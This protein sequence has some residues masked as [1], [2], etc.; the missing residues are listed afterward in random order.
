[1]LNPPPPTWA[2]VTSKK[3]ASPA[4]PT[5]PTAPGSAQRP[6]AR[7]SPAVSLPPRPSFP[8]VLVHLSGD[9]P[10]AAPALKTMLEQNISPH[11][12]GVKVLAC[13]PAGGNG[14]LIRTET[15]DM[16]K[17]ITSAINSHVELSGVCTA[18][19]PRKRVP[20][21]LV[22]DVPA[23]PGPRAL[24]EAHFIEK[25]RS[26][27][28]LPEGDIRVLFRKKGRGSSHHWVISMAPSVFRHLPARGRLHWGF[29][30][31]KFREF[32]E[33]T[34]CFKCHRFG[35]VRQN[36]SAPTELCSRCPGEHP[37][38]DCPRDT[39]VCR[40]CRDYN[41]RNKNGPR[42]SIYHSAI[43]EKCP[44]YLREC[45]ALRSNTQYAS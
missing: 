42:V 10:V 6:I 9:P 23:T 19:E 12:L 39:P 31:L 30:S 35:H 2:K 36:C 16:A 45:E 37:F 32:F 17:T 22:Y 15:A 27:N 14:L 26:S 40:R 11:Q 21:I 18:R 44:L 4:K 20:Q 3:K 33:P 38:K 5:V 7:P 29:G 13:Q 1:M 25:L 34:R 43:S 41:T 28:D 24:E 8:V